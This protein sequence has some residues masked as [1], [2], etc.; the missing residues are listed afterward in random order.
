MSDK[1]VDKIKLLV[2]ACVVVLFGMI[3]HAQT[4]TA[5]QKKHYLKKL[6]TTSGGIYYKMLADSEKEYQF[7][8]EN[9]GDKFSLCLNIGAAINFSY[10]VQDVDLYNKWQERNSMH[11]CDA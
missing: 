3:V 1:S 9:S 6:P 8:I 10:K 2:G 4:N 5:T 7:I 11:R